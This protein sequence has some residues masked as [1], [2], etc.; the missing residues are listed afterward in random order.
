MN[1]VEEFDERVCV[2][3][4]VPRFMN[5]LHRIVVR[6]ALEAVNTTEVRVERGWKL[7]LFLPRM[8]LH[9]VDRSRDPS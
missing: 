4:S 6:V 9:G 1:L 3:K 8:L 2:M 5:G 7:F